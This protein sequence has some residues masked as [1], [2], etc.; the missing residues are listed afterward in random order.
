MTLGPSLRVLKN[1]LLVETF[2]GFFKL[3]FAA[4]HPVGMRRENFRSLTFKERD[5]C[6]N[7]SASSKLKSVL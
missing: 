5:S 4:K 6:S 2:F 7:T 1:F 3:L